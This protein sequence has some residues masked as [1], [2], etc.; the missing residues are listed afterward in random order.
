MK[1]FEEPANCVWVPRVLE[2]LGK[3]NGLLIKLHL[4]LF[5]L[6]FL[7]TVAYVSILE[8]H[9]LNRVH[10]VSVDKLTESRLLLP[11]DF[12]LLI[13]GE[14]SFQFACLQLRVSFYEGVCGCH[15]FVS[16][17][18]QRKD[19]LDNLFAVLARV[20]DSQRRVHVLTPNLK[21]CDNHLS[22]V[23]RRQWFKQLDNASLNL[24]K[25]RV[26]VFCEHFRTTFR[27][28]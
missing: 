2:V 21:E 10:Q 4:G 1:D 22:W 11:D 23:L 18:L 5:E 16:R 14:G 28:S 17:D 25:V 19:Q 15:H 8:R 6:V 9:V 24:V 7:E 20:G 12:L 3:P 26:E 13:H 27:Q